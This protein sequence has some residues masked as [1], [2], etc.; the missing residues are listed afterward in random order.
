MPPFPAAL[1][2][3]PLSALAGSDNEGPADRL[4]LA[5]AEQIAG[6]G[7][8]AASARSI[9]AAGAAASAINY[10]FGSVERLFSTAFDRGAT[11]TADWLG[12]H[13]AH[14]LALPRTANGA[15]C[16]LEYLLGEWTR[17]ARPLALLYQECLATSAGFGPAVAWTGLWRDYWLRTA[18][19]F[20]LEEI[21]GR[22]L[23]AFFESE[24]LYH[25][26]TWSPALETAALREMCDHLALVWLGGSSRAGD[27]ALALAEQAA[28]ARPHG[29]IASSALRI[30]QSA[31]EVVEARGLGGL[32]HRAVATRAGVTTGAVTHHFRTV[33]DLVAGAIRGQVI[34]MTQEAAA[35][36]GAS[37]PPVEEILTAGQL[38][39]AIHFHAIAE[40]PASPALRRRRLFL[41]A[42]R[43]PGLA[44]A[45]AVIRFSHGGT[46]RNALERLYRIPAGMLSLNAGVPSRLLAA[47]WFACSADPS[48][49][50]SRELLVAEIGARLVRGLETR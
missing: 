22:L 16:A 4:V 19:E 9:A 14:I 21:D 43:R 27:G 20:G 6:R 18:A 35:E 48:P 46:L 37:P 7:A 32:T 2:P 24:A 47:T 30:A 5:A 34:A 44:S 38:F 29:S 26:S 11:L 31:V 50:D 45:G 8:A 15:A 36:G 49:R 39:D 13:N 28:G 42:V 40:R 25:L 3:S 17:G 10:N 1:A 41:A 12:R 33:E 23:H